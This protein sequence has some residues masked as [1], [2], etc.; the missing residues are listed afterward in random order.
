MGQKAPPVAGGLL[1]LDKPAGISSNQALGKAKK[2]LGIRKA[3][4]AGTL[5]PFATGLLLCAFGQATKVN[6]FLLEA[7]KTYQATLKLGQ[8]TATGDVEGEIVD[9]AEIPDIT[10]QQWQSLADQLTGKIEQTPPMYSALKYQG[11]PLYKLARQGIT[12]ERAARSITIYSLQITR[13][14]SPELGFTVRCS[15]GTYVR[16]LGEQ[17]A[18]LGNTVGHLIALRRTSIGYFDEQ[19]MLTLEQLAEAA[20][21][22]DALLP[23]DQAL[24]DY[25]DIHLDTDQVRRFMQGQMLESFV[26]PEQLEPGLCR[27]YGAQ[28][29]FLGLGEILLDKCLKPQRL[30][31]T[32]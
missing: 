24:Q 21:P 30:F 11:Q 13:W 12:V 8:A 3:G 31:V 5:D 27:V 26:Q 20:N 6:A 14:E 22:T 16:T 25:P 18:Q 28:E 23:A 7:D 19:P 10:L 29:Q 9:T 1:L 2:I 4:H 15:K 32:Q 17:L